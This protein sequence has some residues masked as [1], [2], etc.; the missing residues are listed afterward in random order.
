MPDKIHIFIDSTI[1]KDVEAQISLNRTIKYQNIYKFSYKKTLSNIQIKSLKKLLGCNQ[2]LQKHHI[3]GSNILIASRSSYKSP[4][5]EKAKQIISNCGFQDSLKIDHLK[6]YTI[7]SDKKLANINFNIDILYD[8]MTQLVFT[9]KN[10]IIEYLFLNKKNTRQSKLRHIPLRFINKYNVKMGLALSDSEIDYLNEIFTKL[11]RDPSDV[12][13]M[14]FAQINSEHCRH[15]IFNSQLNINNS[16]KPLSLFNLIKKTYKKNNTDVVSA[17]TDNCSVIKSLKTK[18]LFSDMPSRKYKYVSEDGLYIIKAE[19]HNHPTAISPHAGAATG[20][21]GELRD[22]GA[23][24][25]GSIPKVGFTGYTLSNLNIPGENNIWEKNSISKPSRIKSALDIIIEAP[26]GAASYNN[27]FGRPNIFGYFR[28]FEFTIAKNSKNTKAIG[29]HKPI[30]LAGGIGSIRTN[31]AFKSKLSNGDLIIILG[32]ASYLIGIGGGAASSLSSGASS[33]DLDFSSVQRDNPEIERRCQEVINQCVYLN[34]DTPIKSIH[35]IG[36]GGLCNA[37]PEIVNESGMGAN[38]NISKVPL[39]EESMSP[40]EIWCNESQERYVIIIDKKDLSRFDEICKRENCPYSSI[41]NVTSKKTLCVFDFDDK[42]KVID[43]PMKFLLGKPPI[44]PIKIS[45]FKKIN[46]KKNKK[47]SSFLDSAKNILM[48]PSVSDKSFLITIGD[49]SVTGLVARDQ[50]IGPHQIPVSNIGITTSSIGSKNGQ[51]LTM[52]ERPLIAVTNPE[53][54]AEIAFGEIIT[55]IASSHIKKLSSIKLSA[56]WMASSKNENEIEGLY[57]AVKKISELCQHMDITIPVGK[58]SLSMNTSWSKNNSQKQVESP[59]SLVLSAFSTIDD[60]NDYKSPDLK[61]GGDLFLIDIADGKDRLGG[62]AFQQIHNSIDDDVPRLDDISNLIH[63]FDLIQKSHQKNL[64]SA[65]HDKSD[66][67]LF[68]TLSEMAL[69][70][71]TSVIINKNLERYYSELLMKKFFFNEELGAVVEINKKDTKSFL[72]LVSSYGL[73]HHIVHLGT[74]KSDTRPSLI[75]KTQRD[76]TMPLSEIRRYWSKL[77]YDIQKLRDNPKTAKEE[78]MSKINTH[79]S[80]TKIKDKITFQ[81]KAIQKITRK[82]KVAILREQG[83]N[84]H[85]EMAHSFIHSGFDAHD[86]HI[87]DLI[88]GNI[89]IAKFEGLVACGGFSYGDVLGAGTGWANKILYNDEIRRDLEEFFYNKNKFSLGVC[90]GCQM[91]SQL[92]QIIP[93]SSHWPRFIK[94]KSNQFEARLSRIK[95][96]KS[97]SIFF[98]DMS[99]SILP[100]IVSHGEG[101]AIF[102]NNLDSKTGIINYVDQRN[103]VSMKYPYNPNGS[104]NGSNGFTNEDGRITILMPHPERLYETSQYSHISSEWKI[105]PWTK[106]FINAREWLK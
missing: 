76:I 5:S 58:D 15:K 106:F 102:S 13:L 42:A 20:S 7:G 9:R 105:S 35:D 11:H 4:W 26:I 90:N 104:L 65:Y 88:N 62:S 36:A 68:V 49:R 18:F 93:G 28:T 82:P 69:A 2:Q 95:I 89:N 71:N 87:N 61:G 25:L 16:S 101:R 34:E 1:N 52:G 41:G 17:Y 85:K 81:V 45:G 63:F 22:E 98:K 86:I 19:T 38:I 72:Q 103:K 32:G 21:G 73:N 48:L 3:S 59:V 12:E 46:I 92:K 33:E 94:N 55:N 75:I 70:G 77:S 64:I 24:G 99:G 6:L 96:N 14:M 43:L 53:A 97:K 74:T 83:V 47:H 91:L 37:V 23:T 39:A 67:G 78:Y 27:E 44:N 40:L 30:M 84:G 50:M 31:H 29:Y 56:N 54:S 57:L 80:K 8:K 60:I 10:E 66:G 51:V 100:V 79:K